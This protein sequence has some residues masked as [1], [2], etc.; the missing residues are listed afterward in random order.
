[1]LYFYLKMFVIYTYIDSI[2]SFYRNIAANTSSRSTRLKCYRA[3]DSLI[4]LLHALTKYDNTFTSS[5]SES[6][7]KFEE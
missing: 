3:V 5:G 7:R 2:W 6:K 4:S 1:M